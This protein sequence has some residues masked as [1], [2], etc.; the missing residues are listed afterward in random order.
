[1][2]RALTAYGLCRR[3]F[4]STWGL[5]RHVVMWIYVAIIRPMFVYAFV[6]WWVKVRQKGFHRKLA[7]LQRTVRLGITGAM[8]TTS[9]AALN[10]L[11]NL[12]A[13]RAA[14]RLIR[15]DLWENNGCGGHRALDE[16]LGGLNL[17]LTMP[18]DSRVICLVEDM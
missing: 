15:L 16:L 10:A 9:G 3:T 1:M 12:Q 8:S 14:H 7:A 2:K 6:V 11:L 13:M 17:V 5:R 18:S 4:A